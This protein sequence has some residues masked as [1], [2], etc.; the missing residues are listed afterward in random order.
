MR[1]SRRSI[2][3]STLPLPLSSFCYR[4]SVSRGK[5]ICEYN[6]LIVVEVEAGLFDL[7]LSSTL[8]H[9]DQPG[10]DAFCN[11]TIYG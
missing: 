7:R 9:Y 2:F 6:L 4:F 3:K 1:S 8:M 5:L 10:F 11:R